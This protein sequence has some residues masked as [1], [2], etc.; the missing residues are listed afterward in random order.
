M[1]NNFELVHVGINTP[2]ADEALKLAELLSMMF[3]LEPRHGQKSEFGGP[4]FECM[5]APFLG[6]NGHIAMQ[7]DDLEA[8]VE[9]LKEKGFS[10]Q[11][12]TAAYTE[13]GKLKNIYLNGEYGG[14][15]TAAVLSFSGFYF[16]VM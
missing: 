16:L 8:A 4:Y 14:F 10:F 2:N 1:K 12:D 15:R 9:E 13:A 3:N 5:K 6:S 11:M 7:T